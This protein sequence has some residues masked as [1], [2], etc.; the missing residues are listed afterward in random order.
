MDI[1]IY[2][3]MNKIKQ[4]EIKR[5]IKELNYVESD[6]L[7]KNEIVNEIETLFIKSVNDFLNNHEELK[8]IFDKKIESKISKIFKDKQDKIEEKK[9]AK[10]GIKT[11]KIKKLYREIAKITHPDKT[12]NKKLNEAYLKATNFYNLSDIPG[13]YSLCDELEIVF[14][15]DDDD[16][17]LIANKINNLKERIKFM[18]STMTWVWYKTDDEIEKNKIII[19]YIK[20][21]LND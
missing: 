15:I 10:I 20:K 18:E 2:N 12:D 4:L 3:N 7:Y 21:R 17:E 11:D 16:I 6:Y 5:L 13:T 14:E 8:D 9:E 1:K 19:E